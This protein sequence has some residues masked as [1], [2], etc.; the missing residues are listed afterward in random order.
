[1]VEE[2]QAESYNGGEPTIKGT[3]KKRRGPLS[4]SRGRIKTT[5]ARPEA[6]ERKESGKSLRRR[7]SA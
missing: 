1:M 2:V 6:Y 4:V 3:G 7:T 5:I